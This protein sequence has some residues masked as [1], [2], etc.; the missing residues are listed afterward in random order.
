MIVY[1]CGPASAA[2]P[3]RPKS[4]TRTCPAGGSRARADA[5]GWAPRTAGASSRCPPGRTTRS[6]GQKPRGELRCQGEGPGVGRGRRRATPPNGLVP[7]GLSGRGREL[8]LGFEPVGP[9]GADGPAPRQPE[10]VGAERDLLGGG[11]PALSLGAEGR[12]ERHPPRP[13]SA[14]SSAPPGAAGFRFPRRGGWP[15]GSL[16]AGLTLGHVRSLATGTPLA[17]SDPCP[18]RGHRRVR[19]PDRHGCGRRRASGRGIRSIPQTDRPGT[20]RRLRPIAAATPS[21]RR[22]STP[23]GGRGGGRE[24]G[25]IPE[26]E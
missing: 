19:S 2:R 13:A 23:A 21:G 20:A 9:V 18:G 16:P 7:P 26:G 3:S 5:S 22:N 17:R 6:T 14:W 11:T 10:V 24:A 4:A 12:S 15:N 25:E 1:G 8:P